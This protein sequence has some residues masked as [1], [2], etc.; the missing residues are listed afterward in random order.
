MRDFRSTLIVQ[1]PRTGADYTAVAHMNN[2][3][4]FG[5][6]SWLFFQAQFD[7]EQRYTVLG[8]G[9]RP[10]VRMMITG[11]AMIVIG[12]MY[13]FYLKP[14]IIRRMK[15]GALA[16]AAAKKTSNRESAEE[17]VGSV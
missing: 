1:D 6:G 14:V 8:V 10:G 16:A 2:P 4:Y 5:G 7:P 9:N 12:L 13:A 3:V 17:V 11:F 15:Q